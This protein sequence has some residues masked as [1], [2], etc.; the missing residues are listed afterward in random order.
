MA[1][2]ARE[3]KMNL[4]VP[5]KCPVCG[6]ELVRKRVEKL[7]RGGDHTASLRIDAEV[8]L[9]CGERLYSPEVIRRFEEI[10]G[11]LEREETANFQPVGKSFDVE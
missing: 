5:E 10:R 3:E 4:H 9:H 2:L 8:C 1:E 11:K 6:G 7:L